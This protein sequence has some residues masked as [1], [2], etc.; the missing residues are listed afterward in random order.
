MAVADL[1]IYN[2][3]I[4]TMDE[5]APRAEAVATA[6]NRIIAVGDLADLE[7]HAGPSTRRIDARGGTLL[8]GFVESHL[9]LFSGAYGRKLL[10]LAAVHGH[11]ALEEAIREFSAANPDEGLLIGQ[12]TPYDILGTDTAMT[13]QVLDAMQPERPLIVMAFDFHTAWA[14]TAALRAAGLLE[15]RDV[16][17]GNEVVVGPDGR[18]TGELREK[19]AIMPVLELRTSGGREMLGMS[20][21]EPATPPSAEERAADI[22]VLKEGMR[23][24]AAQGIT[25]V[26][27]MDGN[28]YMLELL[29]EVEEAGE[30]ACRVE[31]PFHLTVEKPL[32][33]LEQASRMHADFH[34]DMLKSGRVKIFCDGVLE[35]GTA[36][37]IEDYANRPGWRG[38]PIFD[39]ETFR[40]A[41]IEIDRRGLQIS[42]HAIGD[43]AV[44]ITLDSY[45]AARKANGARDSRHRVEHVEMVH[46]DDLPRF[47]ELGVIASM[48][49]PHPPGTLDLPLE[50]GVSAIGRARW[51]LA[52]A[53]R[54]IVDAGA[55]YCFSSDWPIVAVE[56]LIGIQAAMSR[57]PWADDMP[58][59]RLSLFETLAAY[60][61]R[62]AHAAFLDDRT[63]RIRPGMLADLVLLGGDIEAVEPHEMPGLGPVLTI[64]DGRITHE[65]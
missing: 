32:S 20:G 58:D 18:A 29:R 3:R 61:W 9:H 36:V 25:A 50:P 21:Q 1:L 19:N 64:C 15:G 54:S 30:M 2:A 28:R 60:T 49:P 56:P 31:V 59:Q 45:E 57:T 34:S 46:A 12:G 39:A 62:G 47:A 5:T 53:W 65:A 26:H 44:R 63:G 35:S 43:G 40:K 55:Q 11:D 22:E 52:Y 6:G 51:P 33:D 41:A 27:N 42:T 14:N 17:A 37:L 23:Y 38:E 13:R 48:Q 10:Q 8:P 4:L 7:P 24:C 16:G